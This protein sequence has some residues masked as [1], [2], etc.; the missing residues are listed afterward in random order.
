MVGPFER[1]KGVSRTVSGYTGGDRENPTYEEV[2]RSQTNH[3]E[4]VKVYYDPEEVDYTELLDVYWR[5]I[6]PTDNGGQFADRG[7]QYR[8]IIFVQ[9]DS[10][11]ELAEASKQALE[12]SG[13]FEQPIVVPIRDA[14]L[15][16]EAEDYHQDYHL[17]NSERYKRYFEGSGRKAFLEQNWAE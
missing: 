10:E 9:N 15:F 3:V 14:V 13:K 16:Y 6:D 4:A 8:P 11:R 1:L 5:Q 12:E 17:K 7:A 2:V